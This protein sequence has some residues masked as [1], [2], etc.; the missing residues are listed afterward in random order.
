MSRH[1]LGV[2][3]PHKELSWHFS[4]VMGPFD[5]REEAQ[6]AG[7]DFGSDFPGYDTWVQPWPD[8]FREIAKSVPDQLADA[9]AELAA[10]QADIAFLKEFSA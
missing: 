1:Y 8:H 5:T 4:A 2:D 7:A 6:Q 3:G 9:R 10:I